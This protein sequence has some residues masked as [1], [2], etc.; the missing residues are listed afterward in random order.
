MSIENKGL[1]VIDN[2]LEDRRSNSSDTSDILRTLNRY[3]S[4]HGYDSSYDSGY[5]SGYASDT[6]DILRT[7]N[8]Y[9]SDHGYDSGYDSGYGSGYTSAPGKR[10]ISKGNM[11]L[12]K[13]LFERLETTIENRI[14]Y[15]QDI[16]KRWEPLGEPEIVRISADQWRVTLHKNN[17]PQQLRRT[18]IITVEQ[19]RTGSFKELSRKKFD[20]D[21]A[22]AELCEEKLKG[23]RL[24][25]IVRFTDTASSLVEEYQK[26][27]DKL[28]DAITPEQ[29]TYLAEKYA[30]KQEEAR[31]R[32][33]KAIKSLDDIY[34]NKKLDSM[35]LA[36]LEQKEAKEAN[37][38]DLRRRIKSVE[39]KIARHPEE[40]RKNAQSIRENLDKMDTLLQES[41]PNI[42]S[43]IPGRTDQRTSVEIISDLRESLAKDNISNAL[44]N[45]EELNR[46]FQYYLYSSHSSHDEAYQ[47]KMARLQ[48]ACVATGLLFTKRG[49]Y[50]D[51]QQALPLKAERYIRSQDAEAMFFNYLLV[52]HNKKIAIISGE[53]AKVKTEYA[54]DLREAERIYQG[55]KTGSDPRPAIGVNSMPEQTTAGSPL[56]QQKKAVKFHLAQQKAEQTH[57]QVEALEKELAEL[58]GQEKTLQMLA[59]L[60][61]NRYDTNEARE[62]L[63]RDAIHEFDK[64]ILENKRKTYQER[65]N[66]HIRL[67]VLAI[68]N[69][70]LQIHTSNMFKAAALA[71][72]MPTVP[73]TMQRETTNQ[74]NALQGFMRGL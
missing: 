73:N 52:E 16:D 44:S 51:E 43:P 32:C 9:A 25:H 13:K 72:F 26:E 11:P 36:D 49:I 37:E 55:I 54:K 6:G 30:K 42:D 19:N 20:M 40:L 66:N 59:N 1:E 62:T 10:R 67:E 56:E 69:L 58:Q 4:D 22:T 39:S 68:N 2:N 29:K 45:T 17:L 48:D 27:V 46:R 18:E 35:I 12:R 47:D 23:F 8:R 65:V 33:E 57:I 24:N 28:G 74:W 7:L 21:L 60:A 71:S 38:M 15:A 41:G 70:L 63:K 14:R 53:L 34:K 5:G 31:E 61:S 3:A 64:L 50:L